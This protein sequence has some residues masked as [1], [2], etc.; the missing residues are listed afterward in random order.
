MSNTGWT[1]PLLLLSL[2]SMSACN[3]HAQPTVAAWPAFNCNT[4]AVTIT[5]VD[6]RICTGTETYS[7]V[8]VLA[9]ATTTIVFE[10]GETRFD[11]LSYESADKALSGLPARLEVANARQAL[12]ALFWRGNPNRTPKQQALLQVFG[13][14]QLMPLVLLREKDLTH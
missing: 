7:K 4:N 14:T 12:D 9:G 2:F 8:E 13:K 10:Q 5:F 11:V 1:K 3:L 6:L